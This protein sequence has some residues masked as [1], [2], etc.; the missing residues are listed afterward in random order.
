[1]NRYLFI[2]CTYESRICGWEIFDPKE[3]VSDAMA[4]QQAY[5]MLICDDLYHSVSVYQDGSHFESS[6][7][8]ILVCSIH[9]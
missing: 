2:F 7:G 6:D 5:N 8:R 3:P 9:K 1:M 4:V